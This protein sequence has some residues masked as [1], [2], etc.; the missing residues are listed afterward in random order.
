MDDRV[1]LALLQGAIEAGT[2]LAKGAVQAG[3]Q[4]GGWL[5]RMVTPEETLRQRAAQQRA[6]QLQAISASRAQEAQTEWHRQRPGL[7]REAIEG[8]EE[9]QRIREQGRKEAAIAAQRE[10]GKQR[11]DRD[12]ALAAAKKKAKAA[13]RPRSGA[14]GS[15]S[16]RRLA[17]RRDKLLVSL[18]RTQL[19]G[20]D[21]T[22]A[23]A[24][25]NADLPPDKRKQFGIDI[26]PEKP[27]AP[28][29]VNKVAQKRAVLALRKSLHEQGLSYESAD[30]Q[31]RA[32]GMTDLPKLADLPVKK[33]T[34]AVDE[35]K[36][37]LDEM[38]ATV[39]QQQRWEREWNKDSSYGGS[40]LK[41][42]YPTDKEG[43]GS[44]KYIDAMLAEQGKERVTG[45]AIIKQ[46]KNVKEAKE[47]KIKPRPTPAPTPQPAAAAPVAR[48]EEVPVQAAPGGPSLRAQR[49][50]KALT[51]S[52]LALQQ[53]LEK[54]PAK[55]RDIEAAMNILAGA[56]V[57]RDK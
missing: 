3:V 13:G 31:L 54:D 2:G 29:K 4:P 56:V 57:D 21:N 5:D 14:T 38:R 28:G 22:G 52:Q 23:I 18:R 37:T 32:L 12:K 16:D 36:D 40:N 6:A 42:L 26:L 44:D 25:W 45:D 50:A 34:T 53:R 35:E 1:K 7:E 8:R 19:L 49:Y 43:K 9:V 10:A 55:L 24:A 11:I 20:V 41:R 15:R 51:A 47:G 33:D 17:G 48:P 39:T 30:D 46:K 27:P